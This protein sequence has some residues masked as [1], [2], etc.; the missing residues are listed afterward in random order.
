MDHTVE[1]HE[2]K[3]FRWGGVD[4]E[5]TPGQTVLIQVSSHGACVRTFGR[6]GSREG[7]QILFDRT[8]NLEEVTY[9]YED[10]P[11]SGPVAVRAA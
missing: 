2:R 4:F 7:P 6:D 8:G 10:V 9:F 1:I 11:S 3:V 5:F